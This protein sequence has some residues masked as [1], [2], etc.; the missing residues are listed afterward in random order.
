M[1][2]TNLANSTDSNTDSENTNESNGTDMGT[3][4]TD[5]IATVKPSAIE[6]P[7]SDRVD[8]GTAISLKIIW[9]VIRIM[10]VIVMKH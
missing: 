7:N 4:N 10:Q 1:A 2:N 8:S 5:T 9:K 3:T 6:N